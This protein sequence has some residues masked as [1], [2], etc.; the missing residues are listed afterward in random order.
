MWVWKGKSGLLF[1][2]FQNHS[3]EEIV[4]DLCDVPILFLGDWGTQTLNVS[5]M[6]LIGRIINQRYLYRE[7]RPIIITTNMI[8][9]ELNCMDPR[10][11]SRLLDW[12]L[13][14][15]VSVVLGNYKEQDNLRERSRTTPGEIS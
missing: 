15:R 12:Q 5:V 7:L 13:V 14:D 3:T 6:N 1:D 11:A 8:L 10:I 2:S 9:E 4:K